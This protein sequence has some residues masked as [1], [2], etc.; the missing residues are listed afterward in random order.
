MTALRLPSSQDQADE[1]ARSSQGYGARGV[2]RLPPYGKQF[3][4]LRQAGKVP[5]KRVMVSFDW[6]LA[7]AYPRIIIPADENPSELEFKFLAG[8]SVQIIYGCKDAHRVDALV[9]E[10]MRVNPCFLATFALDLV[11]TGDALT[12]IKPYQLLEV[13]EAA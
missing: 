3:M 11:D 4:A 9:Q 6:D 10:I 12:L 1:R 5:S 7:R 2:R 8:L 13:A